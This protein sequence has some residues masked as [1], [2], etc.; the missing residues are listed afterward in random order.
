MQGSI[1]F[2]KK[3][4]GRS[5]GNKKSKH[6]VLQAKSH[7]ALSQFS[8]MARDVGSKKM[9]GNLAGPNSPIKAVVK[10]SGS[11][12]E[13]HDTDFLDCLNSNKENVDKIN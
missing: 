10:G 5:G 12:V 13:I 9:L 7:M 4:K 6:G 3:V 2:S 8:K 11:G 1:G